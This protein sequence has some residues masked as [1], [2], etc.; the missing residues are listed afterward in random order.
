MGHQFLR[1]INKAVTAFFDPMHDPAMAGTPYPQ[2]AHRLASA[3]HEAERTGLMLA[4]VVRIAIVLALALFF[5]FTSSLLGDGYVYLVIT[6]LGFA[7]IGIA[8]VFAAF[9]WPQASWPKFAFITLDCA[10]LA[11]MLIHRH[12]FA[13]DLPPVTTAV[14]EGALLFFTAFLIHSAFSYSPRF[15]L[16]T[17]FS[18][19]IAWLTLLWAAVATPGVYFHLDL[20]G[21]ANSAEVWRR[22]GDSSYLPIVKI[23]YDYVIVAFLTVGLAAA[24]WRSR[25][26]VLAATLAERSRSN[27]SRHFSPAVVD[28]LSQRDKP[29]EQ[30]CWQPAAVLFVDMR[31]FTA[32]CETMAPEETVQLLR[33]FHARMEDC[34]FGRLGTVDRILGD[35]LLAAF[36][37]PDEGSDDATRAL[38]CALDMLAAV[39]RWNMERNA[40]GQFQVHIGIGLHY[41]NVM[42]GDVGSEKLLTFTMIGDTVNVASRLQD[43]SKDMNSPLV[44]SKALVDAVQ[45]ERAQGG[46]AFLKLLSPVGSLS[47][48]GRDGALEAFVLKGDAAKLGV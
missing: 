34:V 44:A 43:M 1:E 45:G 25:R 3:F 5:A 27:L 46:W 17:G 23:V 48:R 33:D 30:V 40:R 18:I 42:L 41:G 9:R 31:G 19:T 28:L 29:F 12:T 8:Q 13:N 2:L 36:G 22:Y 11:A 10:Y 20:A 39:D 16:W 47:V 14:K 7:L 35:G 37:M 21:A 26:L 6:P 32:R 38:G 15:V 4:I 24:V